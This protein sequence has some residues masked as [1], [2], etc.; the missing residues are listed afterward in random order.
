MELPGTP[1]IAKP[2]VLVVGEDQLSVAF[3]I[4]RYWGEQEV[5]RRS[6]DSLMPLAPGFGNSIILGDGRV[7]PLVDLIQLADFSR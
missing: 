5:T 2:T 6:I 7:V 4:D 3:E 1:T